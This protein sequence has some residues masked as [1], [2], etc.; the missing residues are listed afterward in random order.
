MVDNAENRRSFATKLME[1]L[2]VPTFVLDAEGKVIIWNK[3]LE[4]LTGVLAEDVIGTKSHWR[5]FYEKPRACLADMFVGG[6]KEDLDALYATHSAPEVHNGL[7]A[8]NWCVMP[9]ASLRLYLAINAGPIYDEHGDL[10]A[11]VETLRDMTAQ[12]K[13]E[14]SLKLLAN[15][16][17]LTGLANRRAFD[18]ALS[19]CLDRAR[20]GGEALALILGDIDHFK[21]YN[22]HYGHQGGDECLTLVGE[23][24][25]KSAGRPMDVTA[26]Y[27]G[28]E[29]AVI[30]PNIESQGAVQV[31]HRILENIFDRNIPH[32]ASAT[33]DRV[34]MS[35]GVVALVPGE[36]V[37]EKDMINWA[38]QALYQAKENGRNQ[39]VVQSAVL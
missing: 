36:A 34:T 28:E 14:D 18:T 20:K 24:I 12:K 29:F 4:R 5:G 23:T 3:A 1:D 22:D 17:K 11:V 8:E 2:I 16:D 21:A 38:D 10:I 15:M 39:V 9:R 35:L 27:G 26:R 31:A 37:T 7:R 25:G 33:A 32:A 19:E 13:A 30:L 6:N